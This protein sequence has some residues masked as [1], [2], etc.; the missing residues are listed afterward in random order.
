MRIKVRH[1]KKAR[2]ENLLRLARS[3]HLDTEGMSHGQVARLV[4]WRITRNGEN[5]H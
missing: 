2:F 3:L 1:L 5:R 4:Y